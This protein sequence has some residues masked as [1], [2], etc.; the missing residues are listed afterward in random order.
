MADENQNPG[1][2]PEINNLNNNQPGSEQEQTILQVEY[3]A[4]GYDSVA[5]VPGGL[6]HT[7]FKRGQVIPAEML[8]EGELER[9]L[10]LGAIEEM[11]IEPALAPD[12]AE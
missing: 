5:V 6:N 10:E 2:D 8:I 11:V 12:Q 9:L 1:P 3:R 7:V 4:A